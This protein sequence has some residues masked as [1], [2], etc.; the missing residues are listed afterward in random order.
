[1]S[2]DEQKSDAEMGARLSAIS[3][4]QE[5]SSSVPEIAGIENA[6]S[7]VE[8]DERIEGEISRHN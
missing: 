8:A 4:E 3:S 1:M 7:A 5:K 6:E 2:L